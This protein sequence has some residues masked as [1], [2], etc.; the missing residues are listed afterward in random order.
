MLIKD[1]FSQYTAHPFFVRE[2]LIAYTKEA[3]RVGKL[4]RVE[5]SGV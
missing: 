5:F 4:H 1:V 3:Y 2:R